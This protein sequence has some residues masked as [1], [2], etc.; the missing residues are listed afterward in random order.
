[1][2]RR[3]ERDPRESREPERPACDFRDL[4][5]ESPT[6]SAQCERQAPPRNRCR[7]IRQSDP[8]PRHGRRLR[9]RLL[10]AI[11][12]FGRPAHRALLASRASRE[13]ARE[14][15]WPF[16]L[17]GDC[18][19]LQQ[20]ADPLPHVGEDVGGSLRLKDD[21]PSLPVK[22]LQMIR[23]DHSGDPAPR[24]ES[25]LERVAL[26]LTGDRAR[27]CEARFRVVEAWRQDQCG[28]PAPLF[29]TGLRVERQPHEITGVGHVGADYH[30]SWPTGAPQSLST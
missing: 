8:R 21:A 10:D 25:D 2:R 11:R 12:L 5:T 28:P 24:W 30:A 16:D 17:R 22:I 7:P 6:A 18:L 4:E 20:S 1:M 9:H 23:K 29:M 3:F 26:R 19:Q 13:P 27:D 15:C 14:R